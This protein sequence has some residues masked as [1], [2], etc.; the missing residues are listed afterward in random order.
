[1][2]GFQGSHFRVTVRDCPHTPQHEYSERHI[3]RA[4]CYAERKQT[5]RVKHVVSSSEVAHLWAHKAQDSARNSNHSVY[6]QGDTIFSYG[7]H[8]PIARHVTNKAG[9]SAVLFTT[10]HYSVTTSGHCSMVRSAVSHLTVF[11]VPNIVGKW[12][13]EVDHKANL[14]DYAKRISAEL[15]KSARARTSK[16]WHHSQA[17]ELRSE[18]IKYAGFFRL[19]YSKI[20]P[21][22]PGLDS[23]SLAKIKQAEDT[24]LARERAQKLKENREA[25][26]QWR[27]GEP[28]R[29]PYGLPD[30]LRVSSD[31]QNI[32]TSRG[33]SFPISHAKRGLALVRSV[34]SRGETWQTNGH[35]CV[36]GHYR[37]DSILPDGTVKAGCHTVKY[38]EIER[39]AP[40]VDAASTVLETLESE[41]SN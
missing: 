40:A 1:M 26:E 6:F 24:R 16:E 13:S 27:N 21:T 39:I 3:C 36:L 9:K 17:L 29:L 4:A 15:L 37:I 25:I 35:T 32:E 12:D 19:A 38:S 2:Q 34:R 33:V 7:D 23:V 10:A 22:V 14:A 8:F 20:L 18:A 41:S 5:G 30:M 11:D 31:G 28:V